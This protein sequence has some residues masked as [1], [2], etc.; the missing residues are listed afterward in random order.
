MICVAGE[1]EARRGEGVEGEPLVSHYVQLT[2]Q[3]P[4]AS[5]S[6]HSLTVPNAQASLFHVNLL[7][8][9]KWSGEEAVDATNTPDLA[10]P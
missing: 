4:S 1:R 9:L 7:C 2:L 10:F 5:D 3:I 8:G 6:A